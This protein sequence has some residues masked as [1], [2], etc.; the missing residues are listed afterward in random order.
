M[1]NIALYAPMAIYVITL[2]VQLKIF[3]RTEELLALKTEL[4]QYINEH[5]I[6]TNN[7]EINHKALQDQMNSIAHEISEVKNLLIS[8]ISN[9]T[10]NS[11]K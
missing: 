11:K 10:T 3:A 7:Y 1:E 6:S 2:L 9:Q 8:I 4:F 5:Y